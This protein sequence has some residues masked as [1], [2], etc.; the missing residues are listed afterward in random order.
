MGCTGNLQNMVCAPSAA[1]DLD[2]YAG[3]RG[4]SLKSAEP[5][6]G[7]WYLGS[8][9]GSS[10]IRR[11]ASASEGSTH[12]YT[13]VSTECALVSFRSDAAGCC[14]LAIEGGAAAQATHR[15]TKKRHAFMS[16]A[17]QLQRC[18]S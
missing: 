14:A 3:Q 8:L 5:G 7:K 9:H 11:R 6:T 10:C 16:I 4:G 12:Q 1:G 17:L 13:L 2:G 18:A 15:Q